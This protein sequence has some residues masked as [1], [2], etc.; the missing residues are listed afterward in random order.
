MG[1]QHSYV[2]GTEALVLFYKGSEATVWCCEVIGPQHHYMT[3]M[4][5]LVP[6]LKSLETP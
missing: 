2:M 6:F 3:G 4:E 5:D 1:S